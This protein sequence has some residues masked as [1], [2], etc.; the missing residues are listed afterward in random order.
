MKSPRRFYAVRGGF[1]AALLLAGTVTAA[2]A[3]ESFLD[4]VDEALT[5]TAFGDRVR[6][7]LSGTIELEYYNF[8]QI[9]TYLIDADGHNLFNPRFSFFLDAQIGPSFYLFVQ[10]RVDRGFDPADESIRM[11]LD[12]I[13]LRFTPWEDGRFS[14]QIGKFATVVGAWVERHLAWD[15]PFINAP[16]AYENLTQIEESAAPTDAFAFARAAVQEKYEHNPILWGPVYATGIAVSGR[17]GRFS[18]A[19][20]VKNSALSSRPQSWDSTDVG[21]EHPTVSLRVGYRP[22][23]AWNFGFSASEGAYFRSE[24][25]P[26]LPRG[27]GIGDYRQFVLGQDI[28]FAWHKLQLWAEFIEARFEVPRVGNADTFSYFLEAKYKFTTQLFGALRW[29]QQ[30]YADVPDGTGRRAPWGVDLWRVDSA[31][32]FRFTP[33]T[34]LKL[35]YSFEREMAGREDARHTFAA[36]FTVKY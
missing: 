6:A 23:Q 9:P 25:G 24:A 32:G 13:A 16:L 5:I 22:D 1:V 21:F 33:H 17:L 20:E 18:Y 19:A 36:Q 12:E 30:L 3:A 34:Q 4:R 10:S 31:L 26:T 7:R 28:S 15:N 14:L 35:Q 2:P 29:N 27:R 11:R 8:P